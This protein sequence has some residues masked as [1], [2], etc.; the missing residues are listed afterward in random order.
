M[1]ANR[2][3]ILIAGLAATAA[4]AGVTVAATKGASAAQAKDVPPPPLDGE[5]T[6]DQAARD[7]AADDFGHIVHKTPEAVLVPGSDNDV[8]ATIKWAA[9]RGRKFAAQGQSHSVFGRSE[10]QDGVVADMSA[11]HS[12]GAVQNDKIVVD[13]G[14]KWSEVLAATLPAGKTPPVLCD[15]LEL[16]VG[17]TIVVGG[18]GATTSRYGVQADN[19]L[20]MDV[21]T[22]KGE[23]VTC[24]AHQNSDLFNAVRAGLGQVGVI[25]KATLKLV[26][27]PASARRFLL[28]YPDLATMLKDARLLSNSNNARFDVVQ[29]AILPSPNGGFVF[30]LDLAKFFTGTA[31]DDNALLA[32]LS[33]DPAKRQLSTMSY[34]DYLNKLSALEALLR[35]NGQWFY[36]HPWITTFVGDSKVE[37]IVGDEIGR[38]NPPVDLGQFG[39]VVLSPIRRGAVTSPLLRMPSDAL[40]YAF[41]YVRVPTT[42]DATAANQLVEANKAMYQRVKNAGGTL[43]PASSAFPLNKNEWRAHFGSV[44]GR[45]DDAKRRYDPGHVLTPGYEVF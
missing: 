37:S 1:E 44:F 5:L 30:R 14:A 41:N 10:V 29:G 31:P 25:T 45:L 9:Q 3:A 33:D 8:A 26:A 34:F 23:K 38:L 20:E 21:V 12:V 22:G 40:C 43:Y 27:A 7:A 36:P 42:D 39:Q 6:F 18:V 28:V 19:V 4:A 2:R 11:R 24:S 13:A 15:Y 16:S 17:G 32:G 35:G